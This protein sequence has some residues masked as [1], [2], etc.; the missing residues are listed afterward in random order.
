MKNS[1]LVMIITILQS[2]RFVEIVLSYVYGASASTDVI[3]YPKHPR[4]NFG[5]LALGLLYFIPLYS[6]TLTNTDN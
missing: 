5:L 4:R 3:S 6:R 1:Y 2:L